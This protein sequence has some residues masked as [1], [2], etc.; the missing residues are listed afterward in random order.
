[1][2]R[3]TFCA[4]E[5]RITHGVY[6]PF[7]QGIRQ[8][9]ASIEHA[10]DLADWE[11]RFLDSESKDVDEWVTKL[12]AERADDM[13]FFDERVEKG[14]ISKLQG[15]VDKASGTSPFNAPEAELAAI[16]ALR[17]G[18]QTPYFDPKLND[19]PVDFLSTVDTTGGNSGSATLNGKG[20]LVGFLFDGTYDTVASDYLFDPVRTRS[21]HVDTRYMLWTMAEVDGATNLIEE[22][23]GGPAAA[24]APPAAR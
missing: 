10:P 22:I 20:E 6:N 13:A 5:P 12:L 24:D 3:I 21:I 9:R 2:P 16:K 15:I 19:V 7:S 8:L 23:A 4:I 17:A 11:V 1:M 14:L 18:K